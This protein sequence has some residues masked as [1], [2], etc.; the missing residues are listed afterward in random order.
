[1]DREIGGD[2]VKG[3]PSLEI[4]KKQRLVIIWDYSLELTE[5]KKWKIKN[6]KKI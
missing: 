2:K 5:R 4:K 3:Q 6:K 1:M